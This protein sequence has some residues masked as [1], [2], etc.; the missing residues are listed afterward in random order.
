MNQ[1][2]S[3]VIFDLVEHEVFPSHGENRSLLTLSGIDANLEIF[4]DAIQ[5]DKEEDCICLSFSGVSLATSSSFP[6]VDPL[7]LPVA[8]NGLSCLVSIESSPPARAWTTYWSRH[9]FPA[10]LHYQIVL[11]GEGKKYDIFA[12][13]V[14]VHPS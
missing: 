3:I 11:T 2:K 4:F 1:Q 9:G 13:A 6:G 7:S 14:E 8:E 12:R 5:S 10:T